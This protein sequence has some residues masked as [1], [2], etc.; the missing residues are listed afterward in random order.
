MKKLCS[1]SHISLQRGP[2]VNKRQFGVQAHKAF[3][4]VLPSATC[5]KSFGD[6]IF[7]AK[8]EAFSVFHVSCF[9]VYHQ[10]RVSKNTEHLTH[11]RKMLT[12]RAYGVAR[13]FLFYGSRGDDTAP[14]VSV[15]ILH[16]S[17]LDGNTAGI[18]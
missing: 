7:S 5:L 12:A 3:F 6:L 1:Y 18:L 4:G 11:T 15:F 14:T 8:I 17:L 2:G 10:N 16:S 9:C 13:V